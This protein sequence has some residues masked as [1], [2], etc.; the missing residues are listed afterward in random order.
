MSA[1]NLLLQ[2]LHDFD[3]GPVADSWFTRIASHLLSASHLMVGAEPHRFVEIEFYYFSEHHPDP[4]AHRNP[5]QLECGRWYFHR[6]GGTYRNGSF[7]GLDLTFGDG[8]AFGGI[9]VRSIETPDGRLIDGPSLC[10]D[11]LL[12]AT[13]T[14]SVEYLDDAIG[15]RAAWETS[16]PL[17]LR[18]LDAERPSGI[19]RSARVGLS[20]K[21]QHAESLRYLMRP[22]RYLTET[23][24]VRKGKLHL[25][26]AL[27][28]QGIDPEQIR[29]ITGCPRKS[30]GHYIDDFELGR[31]EEDVT[32]YL[33]IDLG[34][35]H[36]CRLH[37]IISA[38]T[39]GHPG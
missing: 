11:H 12:A 24:R 13:G 37:G 20:L 15:H 23:R 7:K 19:V 6:T 27:H 16:C 18:E 25:V 34:P 2:S 30:I 28:A 3:D 9:L 39:R 17:A 38:R 31:K 36:L 14:K 35:K 32:P 29:E 26:L 22:Y 1:W 10:V 33:G 21:K 4:F 8:K 5:L